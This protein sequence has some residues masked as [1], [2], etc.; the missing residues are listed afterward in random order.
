MDHTQYAAQ[1]Q[2]GEPSLE[3]IREMIDSM[4]AKLDG[5]TFKE[6]EELQ[7]AMPNATPD[8]ALDYWRATRQA[9]PVRT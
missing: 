6:I 9:R 2:Q 3:S 8:Q 1:D 5:P 4:A 7:A